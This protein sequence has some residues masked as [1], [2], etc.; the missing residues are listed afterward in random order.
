LIQHSDPSSENF[1]EDDATRSEIDKQL[2]EQLTELKPGYDASSIGAVKAKKKKPTKPKENLSFWQKLRKACVNNTISSMVAENPAYAAA[3]GWQQ[4]E[5][6][7]WNQD[8]VNDEGVKQLRHN[9]MEIGMSTPMGPGGL[10]TKGAGAVGNIAKEKALY[11]MARRGSKWATEKLF[12]A[13]VKEAP[14]IGK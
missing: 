13:A 10:V 8:A 4:D 14:T 12:A 2:K 1:I 9:L 3:V 7:D 6:G 11:F 5:D